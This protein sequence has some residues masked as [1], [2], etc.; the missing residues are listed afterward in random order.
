MLSQSRQSACR[1]D[2]RPL[3]HLS[4]EPGPVPVTSI[5]QG[6]VAQEADRPI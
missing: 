5:T 2:G 1:G 4:L 3:P 6:L